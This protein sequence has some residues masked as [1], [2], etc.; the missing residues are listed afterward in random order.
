MLQ[1]YDA[2]FERNAK[3]GSFYLQSKVHKAKECLEA[4]Y[5]DKGQGNPS[6]KLSEGLFA[7]SVPCS[8]DFVF[9]ILVVL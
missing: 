2:L 1:K 3:N 8:L 5:R 6:W 7:Y 9:N 4:F